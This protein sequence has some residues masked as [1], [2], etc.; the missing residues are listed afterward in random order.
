VTGSAQP[1][2]GK[3]DGAAPGGHGSFASVVWKVAAGLSVAAFFALVIWLA[4][5]GRVVAGSV[6]DGETGVPIAGATVAAS[7]ARTLTDNAG[8]FT[9]RIQG[10]P[11]ALTVVADGYESREVTWSPAPGA[12]MLDVSLLPTPERVMERWLDDW[13]D[14]NYGAMYERLD[15]AARADISRNEFIHRVQA[16]PLTWARVV[17]ARLEA[18]RAEV[19]TE[20]Q[21]RRGEAAQP[22]YRTFSLVT[23]KGGWRIGWTPEAPP[24]AAPSAPK[25]EEPPAATEP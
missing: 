20:L 15:R 17:R 25:P 4:G 13:M 12:K 21:L 19:E 23:E 14:G 24:E 8:R 6:S 22:E 18:N 11:G 10:R 3:S 9:L 5:R 16:L 7:N 2:A 1:P